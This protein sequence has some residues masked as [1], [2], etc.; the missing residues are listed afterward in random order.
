LELANKEN[1]IL[2]TRDKD[3]GELVYRLQ[4]V[5]AGIILIRLEKLK[6]I[7][8]SQAVANFIQKI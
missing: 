7:T 1:R 5:H 4:Q 6:S 8:R 3:F 2:L